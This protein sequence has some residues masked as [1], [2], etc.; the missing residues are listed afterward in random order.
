MAR[1][2][3]NSD[4]FE[5]DEN[6]NLIK[7]TEDAVIRVVSEGDGTYFEPADY[8]ENKE[9]GLMVVNNIP[10]EATM[11][12]DAITSTADYHLDDREYVCVPQTPK[13]DNFDMYYKHNMMYFK[14]VAIH[15][16]YDYVKCMNFVIDG[17]EKHSFAYHLG[18]AT[19]I[20]T[21]IYRFFGASLIVFFIA[22]LIFR[23]VK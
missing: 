8:K 7:R 3:I 19:W 6:F 18:K 23:H 11:S 21:F 16:L 2:K 1:K 10:Y 15:V 4:D 13:K 14:N 5:Q 9:R 22:M 12:W 17:T 20:S